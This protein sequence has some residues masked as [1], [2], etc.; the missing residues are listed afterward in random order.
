MYGLLC[1]WHGGWRCCRYRRRCRRS[2]DVKRRGRCLHGCRW[3]HRGDRRRLNGVYGAR[4]RNW[5]DILL[6]GCWRGS[7]RRVRS[8]YDNGI[9][10]G[11]GRCWCDDRLRLRGRCVGDLQLDLH[12]VFPRVGVRGYRVGFRKIGHQ[13]PE[14]LL[15]CLSGMTRS[16]QVNIPTRNATASSQICVC[17]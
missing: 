3:N 13:L 12:R 1:L 8:R 9:G 7:R 15:E 6:E 4:S 11:K 14:V 5:Q 17:S 16:N 2:G 10:G